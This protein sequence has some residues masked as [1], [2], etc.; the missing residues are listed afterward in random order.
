ME[1]A[2]SRTSQSKHHPNLAPAYDL[3]ALIEQCSKDVQC[4]L[5]RAHYLCRLMHD[6]GF[7]T[8][9]QINRETADWLMVSVNPL[10]EHYRAADDTF[11]KV[12]HFLRVV[13]DRTCAHEEALLFAGFVQSAF[14]GRQISSGLPEMADVIVSCWQLIR[15]FLLKVN[16]PDLAE[17]LNRIAVE[18]AKAIASQH[19]RTNQ[20]P[21]KADPESDDGHSLGRY[22]DPLTPLEK[23]ILK[24]LWSRKHAVQFDTLRT[25][26]WEDEDVSDGGI[27]RRLKDVKKRWAAAG[28]T[29]IDLEISLASTSVKLL[30][31]V[32]KKSDEKGDSTVTRLG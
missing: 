4:G 5:S 28:L 8:L 24:S 15:D 31:P 12:R 23:R 21:G 11:R 16:L 1:R 2:L 32:P 29:D 19:H 17:L 18:S 27:D 22:Q 13:A 26:A 30:K 3:A 20:Q 14:V 25:E 6:F 10:L 7:G 9:D